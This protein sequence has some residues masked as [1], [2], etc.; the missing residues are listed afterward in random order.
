MY[1]L[2]KGNGQYITSTEI[3]VMAIRLSLVYSKATSI[4]VIIKNDENESIMEFYDG[5][6]IKD[7]GK[8]KHTYKIIPMLSKP[9][10]RRSLRKALADMS[11]LSTCISEDN[12]S[13]LL[14]ITEDRYV[15]V[16]KEGEIQ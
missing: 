14:D 11:A 6:L 15:C 13:V 10:I 4:T 1:E 5:T 2:Y 7:Y 12:T 9:I 16:Y 8:I 3:W